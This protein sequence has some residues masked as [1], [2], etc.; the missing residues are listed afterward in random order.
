MHTIYLD[1]AATSPVRPRVLEKMTRYYTEDFGNPSSFYKVGQNAR[2]AVEE[3]RAKVAKAINANTAEIFFTSGGSE[4]DNWAIKA[5]SVMNM[6]KGNHVIT[7]KIEHP[8]VLESFEYLASIGFKVTYLP[9]DEYGLVDPSTFEN[10][11][12]DSTILASVMHANNEV[13][14]IQPIKELAAIAHSRGVIFHTDAVQSVGHIPV[15]VKE[16]G[17][18]MLSI[19]AHKFGGPKGVGT[20]YIKR[21]TKTR[22]F[23][24][25]G[26]QESGKRA[27]TENVASIVGMGEAIE[28]AV[29]ELSSEAP[30][31]ENL[32]SNLREQIT[33]RIPEIKFN[34]HETKCLPN[35]VNFSIKYIEGEGMLIMLDNKNICASS[36]S[37]CSSGSLDPSHVLLAMGLIHETAH[38]SLR[39]SMGLQ[40]TQED[41]DTLV[42]ELEQIVERLR[43]MSPLYNK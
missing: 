11:I 33:A 41:I 25:G 13:G 7:T 30:R 2:K 28:I 34:G 38:G 9:V 27:G 24:H 43:A 36:G 23:I 19:S 6:K 42:Q 4:A 12:T 17:V 15:D 39:I 40:T 22:S 26:E 1:Y 32:R 37:A 8:A 21:G 20:L 14:T 35:I 3:A 5:T 18:D 31:L 10:A 29:S 16:L